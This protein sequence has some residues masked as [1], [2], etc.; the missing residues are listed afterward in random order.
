MAISI[1]LIGMIKKITN[2]QKN[3]MNHIENRS[4]YIQNPIS[5]R[6]VDEKSDT[7]FFLGP[8]FHLVGEFSSFDRFWRFFVEK[9]FFVSFSCKKADFFWQNPLNQIKNDRSRKINADGPREKKI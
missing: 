5:R 2:F 6:P 3:K 8:L 4:F 7:I 9:Y 1:L